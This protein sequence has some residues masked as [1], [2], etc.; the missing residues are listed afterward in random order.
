MGC[1]EFELYP[2]KYY[3]SA[4]LDDVES[5][6][7]RMPREI[8]Y[9]GNDGEKVT[10]VVSAVADAVVRVQKA[11]GISDEGVLAVS[12]EAASYAA[13]ILLSALGN[14]G[15]VSLGNLKNPDPHFAGIVEE[16]TD[17]TLDPTK[18]VELEYETRTIDG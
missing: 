3:D 8:F 6:P 4:L 9:A 1:N 12:R 5:A 2:N 18:A 14:V 11:N 17:I 13:N 10:G 15:E 7:T 16:V